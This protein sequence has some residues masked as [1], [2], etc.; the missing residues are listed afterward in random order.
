[1]LSALKLRYQVYRVMGYLDD[2]FLRT[3]V[4][5]ELNWC[6]RIS[7]HFGLFLQSPEGS[8]RLIGTTRLVLTKLPDLEIGTW[9]EAIAQSHTAL[10][11]LLNRQRQEIAQF[12][13]PALQTLKLNDDLRAE[14]LSNAPWGEISRVIVP[15]E[16]RGCHFADRL[17]E[18]AVEAAKKLKVQELF[19]EC[20]E[21]HSCMYQ[22]CGF[23]VIGQRGEVLGVGKTMLGMRL[24]KS[25]GTVSPTTQES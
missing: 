25:D 6:D 4:A 9:Y 5:V 1:M 18:A 12:R 14:A 24:R 7:R 3:K 23:E 8:E 17:V 15:L 22:K 2:A 13:L 10:Q 20:L 19:L 11:P 16:W 21:M